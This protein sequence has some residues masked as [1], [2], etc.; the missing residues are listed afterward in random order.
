MI[1]GSKMLNRCRI[2]PALLRFN[3]PMTMFSTAAQDNETGPGHL[4][5]QSY[6]ELMHLPTKSYPDEVMKVI[7]C[8]EDEKFAV[9]TL[10]LWSLRTAYQ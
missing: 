4:V 6:D 3:I 9:S 1:I 5:D 7:E 10:G 8:P 2:N